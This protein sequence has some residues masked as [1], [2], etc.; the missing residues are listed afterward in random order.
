[1]TSET[2]GTRRDVTTP[3]QDGFYGPA[4]FAEEVA[5][6]S[7]F[8]ALGNQRTGSEVCWLIVQVI[9][10]VVDDTLPEWWQSGWCV[11]RVWLGRG[12]EGGQWGLGVR[13]RCVFRSTR[14][15][16]Q[17]SGFATASFGHLLFRQHIQF[18]TSMRRASKFTYI[19]RVMSLGSKFA[20]RSN[21]GN[22]T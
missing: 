1:M 22:A 20:R 9:D 2:I 10:N 21:R 13:R 4:N 11:H 15:C 19:S 17:G 7:G 5:L 12:A 14:N 3:T 18:R 6:A 8:P 16:E